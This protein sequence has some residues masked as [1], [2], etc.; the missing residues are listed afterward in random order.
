MEPVKE[1]NFIHLTDE[2][3]C[4]IYDSGKANTVALL[5]Y[6]INEITNLKAEMQEL[7]NRFSKDSHNSNQPPSSDNI[8]KKPKSLRKPTGKKPGGQ[9]GHE[10][11]A[12][13]QIAD[14]NKTEDR[15]P[16]GRC[17]CGKKLKYAKVIN[18][19]IRQLFDCTLPQLFVTQF[20]GNVLECKCGEIHYPEFPEEVVKETQYGNNIKSLAVYLKHYGFISY[21]R[22]EELFSDVFGINISQG[23]LVN[24]VN[25]CATKV[26]PVVNNIKETLKKE[27]VL[28]CDESGMR[29]EKSTAWLHSVSTE[30]LTFYYPHKYRGLKAMEA[31]GIL[32][33]FKGTVIHDHWK[34]Y[35]RYTEC[36][37]ALCNA[38]NLRELIFFEENGEAWASKI[39]DCLLE[40]KKEKELSC[41]LSEIQVKKYRSKMLRLI[42]EGLK[43]YPEIKRKHKTRGRPAQSK[44]FNLLRRLRD[45]INE[46]LRFIMN[47]SVPFDNNQGERDIRMLKIQQKVSGS[48]R[49]MQ[50][51]HSFCK[52]RGYISSI[53]KCGQRVFEALQSVWTDSIILPNALQKKAE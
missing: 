31:I 12:L 1:E 41:G 29:I 26:D 42:N 14:P 49:S 3:L 9:V 47:N 30:T 17:C 19:I 33:D 37:H 13:R 21:E 18:S 32:P 44:E 8:L 50:G 40:A 46:V 52:I 16:K 24:F 38:H 2:Q 36:L 6:L 53:R 27:A 4:D 22:I 39:K 7:K 45:K 43:V 25:E 20:Q 11:Q 34:P 35:F 5:K 28:H 10:G 15:T 23:T 48:F 51:A